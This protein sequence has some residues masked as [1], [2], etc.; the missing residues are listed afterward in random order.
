MELLLARAKQL[1]E[2]SKADSSNAPLPSSDL[3]RELSVLLDVASFE[4]WTDGKLWCEVD[5][6]LST[7]YSKVLAQL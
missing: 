7:A 5:T 1:D 2:N 3:K 6:L 4:D